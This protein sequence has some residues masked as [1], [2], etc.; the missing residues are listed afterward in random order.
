MHAIEDR[1][2][3]GRNLGQAPVSCVRSSL[4]TASR[5]QRDDVNS[6]FTGRSIALLEHTYYIGPMPYKHLEHKRAA[7]RI[8]L[9]KQRQRM[10]DYLGGCCVV[11]GVM[12]NLEFH[13]KNPAEKEVSV[14][15]LKTRRWEIQKIELDKCELRCS[16]HHKEAHT[17]PHG[18][19]R[20][21]HD[22]CRC[23]VCRS[24]YADHH[25]IYQREYRAQKKADDP[26]Y[27][28]KRPV[29]IST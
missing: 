19:S 15:H 5:F 22:G 23:D 9:K 27:R 1:R 6:I 4:V 26:Y 14:G 10:L 21:S 17:A 25:N 7:Q 18:V 2:I 3:E 29:N 11:C 8:R 20:Y 12:E 28:R 24:A 16:L 13:H